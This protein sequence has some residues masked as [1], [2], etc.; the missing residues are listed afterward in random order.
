MITAVSALRTRHRQ[1]GDDGASA[2][3]RDW[4]ALISIR[5]F[6][7]NLAWST[8]ARAV[9]DSGDWAYKQGQGFTQSCEMAMFIAFLA[10]KA[11]R[12]DAGCRGR[13]LLRNEG[14]MVGARG[15][16]PP[17][18]VHPMQVALPGCATPRREV[19]DYT[20][21]MDSGRGGPVF[22]RD[23]PNSAEEAGGA[24]GRP[25]WRHRRGR[26]GSPSASDSSRWRA[27]LMVKPCSYSRSRD[28]PD[29]QNLMVL[30]EDG[31]PAFYRFELC[32]ICSQTTEHMRLDRTQIAY[33]ADGERRSAGDG[34]ERGINSLGWRSGL[35]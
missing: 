29:K 10:E 11:D 19:M 14:E 23:P 1:F 22:L 6:T 26:A 9:P 4:I 21:L 15:F 5:L 3:V 7:E 27:P 31:F 2:G 16:E 12:A 32:R 35:A 13:A 34:R 28:T 20:G 8:K 18:P 30:V 17:T 24:R 33:L 25:A